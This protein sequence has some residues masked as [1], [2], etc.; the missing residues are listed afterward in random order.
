[1]VYDR[2]SSSLYSKYQFAG[3]RGDRGTNG[4]AG[5]KGEAGHG[6]SGISGPAG[7]RGPA[8]PGIKGEMGDTGRSFAGPAGK[9]DN[10]IMIIYVFNEVFLLQQV[11]L[12]SEIINVYYGA[13]ATERKSIWG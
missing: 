10:L 8:G 11:Q 9:S 6:G 5:P 7:P 3:E 12:V 13:L 1:M 2:V 4:Y